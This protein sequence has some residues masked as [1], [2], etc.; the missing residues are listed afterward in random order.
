MIDKFS[1]EAPKNIFVQR[2]DFK[3]VPLRVVS[4]V[5]Y[6]PAELPTVSCFGTALPV[7]MHHPSSNLKAVDRSNDAAE[8]LAPR[9]FE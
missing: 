3:V 4:H 5:S 6:R 2:E 9:Q 7:I 8:P 1:A